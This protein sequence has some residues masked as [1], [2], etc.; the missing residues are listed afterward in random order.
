MRLTDRTD[1]NNQVVRVLDPA[2]P[3][4][5]STAGPVISTGLAELHRFEG[6]G[7][8]SIYGHAH[9]VLNPFIRSLCEE[10]LKALLEAGVGDAR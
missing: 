4:G 6:M 2:A 1:D 3:G 7:H 10:D 5:Q 8:G 9:D